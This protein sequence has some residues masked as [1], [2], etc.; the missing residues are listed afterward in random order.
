MQAIEKVSTAGAV[1]ACRPHRQPGAR[2]AIFVT[3][4]PDSIDHR[5]HAG[6][7]RG[8]ECRER[9][10]PRIRVNGCFDSP[11]LRR[12][13][14]GANAFTGGVILPSRI[15]SGSPMGRPRKSTG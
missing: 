10:I 4:F 14:K 9:T 15:G 6:L 12:R 3:E 8:T 2:G 11:A 1:E 7:L 5:P 13:L